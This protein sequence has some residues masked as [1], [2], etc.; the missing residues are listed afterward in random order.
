MFK[1]ASLNVGYDRFIASK[2]VIGK[3]KTKKS[4]KLAM[5]IMRLHTIRIFFSAFSLRNLF[6]RQPI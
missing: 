6:S 3:L 4:E 1:D 2:A 5:K